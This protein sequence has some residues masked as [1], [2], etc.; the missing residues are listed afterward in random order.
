MISN[1]ASG[2]G[3]TLLVTRASRSSFR[4]CT[5]A[6]IVTDPFPHRRGTHLI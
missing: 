1:G 2:C 5:M 3:C 6:A 4:N